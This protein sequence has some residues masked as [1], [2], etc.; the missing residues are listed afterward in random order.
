[1][2]ARRKDSRDAILRDL[3]LK[4][5]CPEKMTIHVKK[6]R[7]TVVLINGL[8]LEPEVKLTDRQ[9]DACGRF[10]P[11]GRKRFCS[12]KCSGRHKHRLEAERKARQAE[13][14][15]LALSQ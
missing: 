11:E 12:D 2:A 7:E 9:C 3:W 8:L 4:H 15:V 5:G 1:M 6:T 14:S 13:D 10:V